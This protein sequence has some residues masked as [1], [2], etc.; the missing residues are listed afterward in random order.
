MAEPI[1]QTVSV[2]FQTTDDDKREESIVDIQVLDKDENIVARASESW[3]KF[4][5]NTTNGPFPLEIFTPAAR[6]DLKPDGTVRLSWTPWHDDTTGNSDEWHFNLFVDLVFSDS[7][8]MIVD[9]NT[10]KL[11][12]KYNDVLT[13]GL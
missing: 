4:D 1:L 2:T 9:E 3:G 8:H 7:S 6:S 12:Y 5:N 11:A 13:F 10:L